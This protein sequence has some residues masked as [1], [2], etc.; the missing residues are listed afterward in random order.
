MQELEG[1]YRIEVLS[2]S[3]TFVTLTSY[4][5]EMQKITT[6][7]LTTTA[8]T[9]YTQHYSLKYCNTESRSFHHSNPVT[10]VCRS[11]WT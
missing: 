11:A 10:S 6:V 9:Y 2:L 7:L 4:Q 3:L 8:Q 5:G 1:Y